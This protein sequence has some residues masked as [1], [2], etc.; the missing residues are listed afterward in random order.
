[1]VR[2]KGYIPKH[3]R[4]KHKNLGY[5]CLNGRTLYTGPW[6]SSEA[7][8]EYERLIAEWLLNGR[9]LP[10]RLTGDDSYLIKHLVADFWRW[11]EK[12]YRKGDGPSREMNNIRDAVR[13]LLHLYGHTESDEFGPLALSA[14]REHIV[15]QGRWARTTVNS[16]IN[17]IRRIFK[18]A[19]ANEKVP[20][21]VYEGVRSLPGLQRGRTTAREPDPILPVTEADMRAVLPHVAPQVAA[22]ILLQWHTG[23]RPGEVV[24]MRWKDIKRADDWWLYRPSTH[25]TEHFGKERKVWLGENSRKLLRDWLRVDQR[26]FLFSPWEAEHQRRVANREARK[27]KLTPSQ[28]RRD[29]QRSSRALR[30][31]KKHYTPGTYRQAISRACEKAEVDLWTPN[32]IR[33]AVATRIRN[34]FGLDSAQA[35]LGHSNVSVTER[36]A[37]LS[38]AHAKKVMN[39][40]G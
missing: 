27:T 13:P 29:R 12:H 37:A 38:E 25:K 24:L 21:R 32:L 40:I 34:E 18:W 5:V 8:S 33:H 7:E 23:M 39:Q 15:D 20:A 16:R 2:K 35:V 17:I 36:Y 1:M 31:Y 19:A 4:H 26:A 10:Q 6:G 9:Q 22:M 30:R 11:A 14:L 3:C 28:A